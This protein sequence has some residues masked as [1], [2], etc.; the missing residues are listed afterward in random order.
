MHNIITMTGA[1]GFKELQEKKNNTEQGFKEQW[2]IE[3]TNMGDIDQL[4]W[5]IEQGRAIA[6]SNGSFMEQT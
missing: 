4:K 3:E 2:W 5:A 6:V 1:A